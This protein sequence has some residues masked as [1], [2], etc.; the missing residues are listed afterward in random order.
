MLFYQE[1]SSKKNQRKSYFSSFF[2]FF[3]FFLFL[4]S[5]QHNVFAQ[6]SEEAKVEI[7]VEKRKDMT[8]EALSFVEKGILLFS[9][10]KGENSTRKYIFRKYDK[11]LNPVWIKEYVL[12][13]RFAYKINAKELSEDKAYFLYYQSA[14]KIVAILQVDFESG[15][16]DFKQA[17]SPVSIDFAEMQVFGKNAFIVGEVGR[18]LTVLDF[19]FFDNKIKVVP[20]VFKKNLKIRDLSVDYDN[21]KGYIV[22]KKTEKR[23]E[24][25]IVIKSFQSD[26]R[27]IENLEV[28]TRDNQTLIFAK[29]LVIKD[30]QFLVATYGESCKEY[31]NGLAFVRVSP[32]NQQEY[33][34]YISFSDLQNFFKY[35]SKGQQKRTYK[36][37]EKQRAKGK[38]VNY[39]YSIILH[40]LIKKGE[41]IV[42]VGEAYETNTQNNMN[43]NYYNGYSG[44]R[45]YGFGQFNNPYAPMS[46]Y[47]NMNMRPSFVYSHAFMVEFDQNGK[48]VADNILS[49]DDMQMQELQRVVVP[50]IGKTKDVLFQLN[51][52]QYKISAFKGNDS[53]FRSKKEYYKNPN[54]EEYP[55]EKEEKKAH[56]DINDASI[57]S[58]YDDYFVLYGISLKNPNDLFSSEKYFHLKKMVFTLPKRKRE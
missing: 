48:I 14:K 12:D 17:E 55:S 32:D 25:D 20:D 26:G 36:R 52:D 21:V 4:L 19:S 40:K 49:L 56:I 10:E 27:L 47:N 5:V 31:A 42:V 51:T 45:P 58:W 2:L 11:N 33:I 23:S 39:R 18:E 15:E 38:S 50:H 54:K 8:F 28:K 37:I 6:F 46:P 57:T 34:K 44:F 35:M 30:K 7:P 13:N 3:L 1:N 43:N 41:N 22:A 16:L 24:C 53:I 29:H 9:S